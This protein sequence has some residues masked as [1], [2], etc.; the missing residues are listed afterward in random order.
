MLLSQQLD[1]EHVNVHHV[2][3]KLKYMR[4]LQAP[5]GFRACT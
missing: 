1:P 2:T 3:A 5:Q 4:V